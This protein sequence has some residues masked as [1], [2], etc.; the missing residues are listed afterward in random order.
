MGAVYRT[1]KR[2]GVVFF[3]QRKQKKQNCQH[4]P[5]TAKVSPPKMKTDKNKTDYVRHFFTL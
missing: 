3:S 5:G 1:S 2:V 4:N